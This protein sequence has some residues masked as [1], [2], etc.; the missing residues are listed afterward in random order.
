MQKYTFGTISET[1]TVLNDQGYITAFDATVID[2]G[3]T[4]SI[5]GTEHARADL[6]IDLNKIKSVN[7]W[8]VIFA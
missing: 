4:I 1:A 8:E 2:H 3:D 7:G 5:N 6:I